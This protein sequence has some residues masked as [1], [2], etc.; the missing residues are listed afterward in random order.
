MSIE[1]FQPQNMAIK[2]VPQLTYVLLVIE[3][4]L[5]SGTRKVLLN[6]CECVVCVRT[7]KTLCHD[8]LLQGMFN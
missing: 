7:T 1:P 6:M 2:K 4:R 5:F 3:T 8:F